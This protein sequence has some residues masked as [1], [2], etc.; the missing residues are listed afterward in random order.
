MYE[1]SFAE[2]FFTGQPD[3]EIGGDDVRNLYPVTRRP[4]SVMQAL[5]SDE[6]LEPRY[7]KR[8]VKD[9]LGHDVTGPV[10]ETVL[11]ELLD[12]IREYNTCDTLK[13]PID[14]YIDHRFYVTVYEDVEEE[15]A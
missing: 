2:D 12:K 8:M 7:F 5:I 9:V 6:H 1:L 11:W 4:Q 3:G 14:V 10:D 13:P 15:V